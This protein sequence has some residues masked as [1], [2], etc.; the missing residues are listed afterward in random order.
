ME[1]SLIS[2][3]VVFLS[4]NVCCTFAT[5]KNKNV[6]KS[7][8]SNTPFQKFGRIARSITHKQ[9]N[10]VS[11]Q[12]FNEASGWATADIWQLSSDCSGSGYYQVGF[13]LDTCLVYY[14]DGVVGDDEPTNNV[15]MGSFMWTCGAG[16]IIFLDAVY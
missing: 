2:L 10:A 3:I 11:M 8:L 9:G 14:G 15:P 16:K 7:P 1:K 5:E 13:L 4:L 6:L 12:G